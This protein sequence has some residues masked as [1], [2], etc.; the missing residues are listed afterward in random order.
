MR[1]MICY[2]APAIA[3]AGRLGRNLG[4][5]MPSHTLFTHLRS[6]AEP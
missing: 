5:G 4:V 6:C 1:G 2:P 3:D